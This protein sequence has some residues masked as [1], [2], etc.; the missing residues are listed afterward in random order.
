LIGAFSPF[1]RSAQQ[2]DAP[3]DAWV[4]QFPQSYAARFARGDHFDTVGWARRGCEYAD[5][6]SAEQFAALR[7]YSAL[8]RADLDVSLLLDA[9]PFLTYV[10]L[11]TISGE[12]SGPLPQ[13]EQD[14]L[15]V[16]ASDLPSDAP[17]GN[18]YQK[19]L[20]LAATQIVPKSF[21]ARRALMHR[22]ETRWGGSIG[23]MQ[24]LYEQSVKAGL[25]QVQLRALESMVLRDKGWSAEMAGNYGASA[26]LYQAAVARIDPATDAYMTASYFDLVEQIAWSFEQLKIYPEARSWLEKAYAISPTDR[27]VVTNLPFTVQQSGDMGRA[28]LL[29]LQGAEMGIPNSINE[30]GKCQW[31]GLGVA[32]DR[33]GAIKSFA[34]AAD[35]GVAEA[36]TNLYWSQKKL[37]EGLQ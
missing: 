20:F 19:S 6:T 5:K 17:P 27:W 33:P 26:S 10:S 35:L 28:A 34:K 21:L 3:Y 12:S 15:R 24:A 36:K 2:A 37:A 32:V 30:W 18:W 7:H 29:Y 25:P 8:A 14:A 31:F 23:A 9:K 16:I 13:T 4:A 11:I 1:V 22:L